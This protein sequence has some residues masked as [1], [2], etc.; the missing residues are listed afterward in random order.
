MQTQLKHANTQLKPENLK[1]LTK[2][3]KH[4]NTVKACKYTVKT[5][6]TD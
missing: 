5:K 6:L 1:L 4:A 2:L 3:Q